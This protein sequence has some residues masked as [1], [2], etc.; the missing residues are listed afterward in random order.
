MTHNS[1]KFRPHHNGLRGFV[2]NSLGLALLLMLAFTSHF[3]VAEDIEE[4]G[5][6]PPTAASET[7][8]A[9][10][11]PRGLEIQP[12]MSVISFQNL[13]L[14]KNGQSFGYTNSFH[15]VPMIGLSLTSPAGTLGAFDVYGLVHVGYGVKTGDVPLNGSSATQ[16]VKLHTI[17]L[18]V[19]FKA[20][21][22]IPEVPSIKPALVLGLGSQFFHQS[23]DNSSFN[24]SYFLPNI[25]AGIS[26]GLFDPGKAATDWFGGFNFGI[27]YHHGFASENKLRAF[28]FDLGVVVI[29]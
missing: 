4:V 27:N 29:L 11:R 24:S 21:Y 2:K 13:T 3:A 25:I 18:E 28:S 23:S 9:A 17:P 10:S 15:G 1:I 22:H 20:R 6:P 16:Y 14:L 12:T 8:A 19:L 7:T 5:S 26:V